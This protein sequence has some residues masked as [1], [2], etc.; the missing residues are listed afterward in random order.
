MMFSFTRS[1]ASEPW[2]M[3]SDSLDRS[4]FLFKHARRKKIECDSL[5]H[6]QHVLRRVL[7][8]NIGNLRHV[9]RAV[10]WRCLGEH[11]GEAGD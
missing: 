5:S 10:H 7:R 6:A 4:E 3:V 2:K 8:R 9:R 1:T 11:M